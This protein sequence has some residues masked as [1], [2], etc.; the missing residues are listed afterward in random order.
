MKTPQ[1]TCV[2][3]LAALGLSACDEGRRAGDHANAALC[4]DFKAAKSA[5]PALPG[6]G[7]VAVD[8]CARRWAY[9]LAGSRDDADVVA[10]AVAGACSTQLTRWN[11]QAVAAPAGG[12]AV[13]ILT[14]EPT[15]PIAEHNTF[16]RARAL[17]Y[18]VQARAGRCAAPPITNGAPEGVG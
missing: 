13:S 12:E 16:T 8:D 2:L 11:Q 4:Y 3:A 14:G 9:S 5:T 15:S 1:L 7:A 6:D 10:E 18:V 17:F